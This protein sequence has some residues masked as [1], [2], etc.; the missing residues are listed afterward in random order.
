MGVS[1]VCVL[2]LSFKPYL[3]LTLLLLA[4]IG[5]CLTAFVIIWE[6]AVQELL[7]ESVLGRVTSFQ[8]F[9]GLVLLPIGYSVFGFLIEHLGY[10]HSMGLAGEIGRASCRERV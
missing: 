5:F 7:D 2:I 9:G 10:I 3:F 6:S 4:M 1:G 8:M